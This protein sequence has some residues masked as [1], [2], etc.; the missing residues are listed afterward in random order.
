MIA[1]ARRQIA[2][3]SAAKRALAATL[4]ALRSAGLDLDVGGISF[5]PDGGVTVLTRKAPSSGAPTGTSDG[6]DDLR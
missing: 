2:G 3:P 1:R 4:E 5:S 6:W